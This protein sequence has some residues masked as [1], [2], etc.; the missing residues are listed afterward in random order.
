MNRNQ[1]TRRRRIID[2]RTGKE[3]VTYRLRDIARQSVR[4]DRE[5]IA[6]LADLYMLHREWGLFELLHYMEMLNSLAAARAAR[7]SLKHR[8]RVSFGSPIVN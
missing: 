4:V 3:V 6:D 8:T 5:L 1:Q 7:E 2:V